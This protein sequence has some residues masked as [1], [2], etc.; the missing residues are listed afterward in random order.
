[1]L[2]NVLGGST[3]YLIKEA[4]GAWPPALLILARTLLAVPLFLA[5]MP[6]GW[7]G[8]ATR[9]DWL[10]MLAIGL[11][12][13]AAPHLVG[14]YGL[15]ETDS[16]NGAIL[17]GMEP[18]S[19]TVLSWFLL[20]ERLV[21]RQVLAIV[22]ALVGALLVVSGGDLARAA[23][24]SGSVRGNVLLAF[25]G[26]LWA[27]YTVAAKPTLVRVPPRALAAV[28]TLVSLLAV[29]PAG[30]MEL[31]E[32]DPSRAFRPWPL[33]IIVILAVA[34]SFGATVAWNAAL[35]RIKAV[36]MAALIFLQPLTG[37]VLGAVRG[38]RLGL[39]AFVGAALILAG[40]FGTRS[41]GGEPQG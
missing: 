6:R 14:T 4:L 35:K 1:M 36:Q 11:V 10:R 28:T 17:I 26:V 12:G 3:Y 34:I 41:G 29:G 31:D 37:A 9:A 22:G 25:H 7:A 21:G 2:A 40:V 16:L 13:L 32:L 8:R 18:V 15:V 19:I 5:V 24:L 39:A 30:A 38:E 33:A 27:V 23:S 20:G